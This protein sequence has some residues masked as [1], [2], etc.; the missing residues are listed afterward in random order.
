M[1]IAATTNVTNPSTNA[2][3]RA[4]KLL[5]IGT[6][7]RMIHIKSSRQLSLARRCRY[8][9]HFALCRL[10]IATCFTLASLGPTFVEAADISVTV[11]DR[12]GHAIADAVVTVTPARS[13]IVPSIGMRTA[14]LPPPNPVFPPPVLLAATR[15]PLHVPNHHT[16]DP[17]PHSFFPSQ[18]PP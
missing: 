9:T 6:D 15:P 14:A 1:A 8:A 17:P 12:D 7:M 16:L 18:T 5:R 3:M 10:T 11:V 13:G 4:R 2:R